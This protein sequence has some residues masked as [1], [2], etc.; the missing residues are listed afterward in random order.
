MKLI[1]HIGFMKP[2][3]L[4]RLIRPVELRGL[5]KLIRFRK[6]IGHTKLL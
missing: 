5:I 6:L 3:R 1:G 4:M 2:R